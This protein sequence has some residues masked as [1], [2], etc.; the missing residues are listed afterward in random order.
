MVADAVGWADEEQ[1][2]PMVNPRRNGSARADLCNGLV[3]RLAVGAL[4][5]SLVL[6]P[7]LA[8]VAAAQQAAP[9]IIRDTEIEEILHRDADPIFRAA[10]LIPKDETLLLVQDKELNAFTANGLLIAVNTGLIIE[11]SN[12]NEL[13]GVIAHETGHAAGGHI[14]RSGELEKAAMSPFLLTLGLGVLAAAAGAPDAGM[15]L[16]SSSQYF[17]A[18]G[19]LAYSRTQEARADQAGLTYLEKAGLSG[20]GLVD[21]FDKFRY[22][23]VFS[24]ARRFKFFQSHPISSERIEGLRRRAS[25]LK[26]YNDVDTPEALAEHEIM[27]AKLK[28]FMN[29]PQQTFIDYSEKDHSFPARY[30]R[31]IAY[32]R[33]LDTDKAVSLIDGLIADYPDNPYLYEL[34]GQALF[35]S[36]HA[37]EAEVAHRKSVQLKPAAPL[38]H[39]NLAQAIIAQEDGKRAD[40][41]IVELKK[42]LAVE[43]DNAFAWRLMAQ[44]YNAKGDG[45]DARLATA[46]ERYSVGD[47]VQARIFALRAREMLKRDTPEWRRATDIVLVSHPS[48]EDLRQLS[49]QRGLVAGRAP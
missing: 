16:V 20:R 43:D 35:E 42:A 21:F 1:D 22:E 27:K 14:A 32:Y 8:Q 36:G 39:I 37:K 6:S 31:A 29:P 45:G 47:L 40:D 24:E 15:A 10:G 3:R 7:P 41:A 4:S 33:A 26:H 25:E 17:G 23:E 34:K 46:E 30:A 28:A 44:A 12:P 49:G 2:V 19:A 48:N 18:L 11:T 9:Q 5:A 13:Q 38:L